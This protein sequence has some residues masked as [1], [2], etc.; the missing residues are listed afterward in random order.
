MEGGIYTRQH[1][2]LC[3][4][5]LNHRIQDGIVCQRHPEIRAS[6]FIVKFKKTYLNFR[7]FKEAERYITGLRFKADE[8]SYDPRDY[9][10]DN[11]LGF[12]TLMDQWYADKTVESVNRNGKTE[13][14]IKPGTRKN[15]TNYKKVLCAYFGDRN[16]KAI[17]EDEGLVSDFFNTLTEVGNKTKWNYRSALNTFFTWAWR[18]NKK[19]F[20][21]AGIERPELPEITFTLGYRKLVSKDVQFDILQEVKKISYQANPKIYLGIKWLCTYIKVRPG[22]LLSLKEGDINLGTGHLFFP[23]PKENEW[24]AVALT[25][26]DVDILKTFP[27]AMPSMPFFRHVKGISGVA[28]N[29]PFGEKYLYKYWIKACTNLGIEGV[30]LYGG[31][32]H[33]SITA[34]KKKYTPEE[35]R[36]KGTGHKTNRAFD[37]YLEMDS[38]DSRE[39]YISATP[40]KAV[41]P[42]GQVVNMKEKARNVENNK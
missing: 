31:T 1:C 6:R 11:P 37:R 5:V 12:S 35:I 36:Q 4:A 26:E 28:E 29:E 13:R 34:L 40:R 9:Q 21:K 17:A 14:K 38:D 20:A 15:Y 33:S 24:K 41:T 22:E 16:I 27:L 23:D 25:P 32:R 8:G 7:E 30:D 19:A 18:R 39:L 3:G 42:P 2:P 10:K